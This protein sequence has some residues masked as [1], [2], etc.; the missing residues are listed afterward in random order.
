MQAPD[1][2]SRDQITAAGETI[3]HEMNAEIR[4]HKLEDD[5]SV[6]AI[7][8]EIIITMKERGTFRPGEAATLESSRPMLE[9]IARV[10]QTHEAFQV[11]IEGHTDT[12]PIQTPLYPSNWELSVSRAASVL[13]YF[14]HDHGIDPS[15][16]S[17]K[18]SADQKPV[19][20]NDT[21]DNRARNRRVEIRL[22]TKDM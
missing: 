1:A 12:V 7:D 8:K 11:E 16:F 9:N 15:R 10:I 22:K 21:E 14:I 3:L 19:A 6:H 4:K 20:D 2:A 18:G 17:I 5:V 13:R